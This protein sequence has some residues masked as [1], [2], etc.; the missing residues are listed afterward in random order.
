MSPPVQ[1]DN[2]SEACK[3]ESEGGEAPSAPDT[4]AEAQAPGQAT[5]KSAVAPP[6]TPSAAAGEPTEAEL[7]RNKGRLRSIAG[8]SSDTWN[9][10]IAC[11]VYDA[12]WTQGLDEGARDRF[13]EGALLTL[14]G[15]KPKDALE[16]MVAAQMLA[17]H[18]AA[19]ECYRHAMIP[20]QTFD[21]VTGEGPAAFHLAS[22]KR[23]APQANVAP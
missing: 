2:P 20:E 18:N 1:A 9:L 10:P 13:R 23:L 16:G 22:L 21:Y 8:S 11:Q 15:I 17:A 5:A 19:M 7:A 12:V 6:A 3:L 4:E 14:I